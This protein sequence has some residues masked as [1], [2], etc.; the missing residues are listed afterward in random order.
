VIGRTLT[1]AVS[2]LVLGAAASLAAGRE[3]GAMLHGVSAA[4]PLVLAITATVLLLAAAAATFGPTRKA[5]RT[6]PLIVMRAE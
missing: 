1:L 2:G 5:L 6:D 3:L 4:D